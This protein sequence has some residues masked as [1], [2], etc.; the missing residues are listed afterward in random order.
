MYRDHLGHTLEEFRFPHQKHIYLSYECG[1]RATSNGQIIGI[2]FKKPR[3]TYIRKGLPYPVLN[4]S[5]NSIVVHIHAHRLAAYC[6]Y[7]FALFEPG[8]VVRHLNRNPIDFSSDNIAIGTQRE[9]LLD[10][11]SEI[12]RANAIRT[13][14]ALYG[15]GSPAA[16][17]TPAQ[18]QNI[19]NMP[20]DTYPD[21][22]ERLGVSLQTIRSAANRETYRHVT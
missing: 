1:Y 18:V 14:R 5:L 3:K 21:I 4:V 8:I 7:G 6:K 15:Q 10:L 17:L 11:P 2:R 9:N 22:A 19:R 20:P 13:R 16:K 12:R